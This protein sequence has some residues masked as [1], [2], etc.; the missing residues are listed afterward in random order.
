MSNKQGR[1]D[2]FDDPL[3]LQEMLQLRKEGHSSGLLGTKYSCDHSTILYHCKRHNIFPERII[4]CQ[5]ERAILSTPQVE[6]P[7]VEPKPHHKYE[8]L[9]FEPLNQGRRYS[10]YFK[11]L[12][13]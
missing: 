2:V 11:K 12:L 6:K 13:P 9:I 1:G 7:K 4:Q 3:K 5:K 8:H 10:Q